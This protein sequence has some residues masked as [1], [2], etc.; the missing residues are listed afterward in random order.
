MNAGLHGASVTDSVGDSKRIAD[1]VFRS[2][3]G[4]GSKRKDALYTYDFA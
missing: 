4:G 1:R 3:R 2:A